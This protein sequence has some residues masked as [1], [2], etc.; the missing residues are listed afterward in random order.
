MVNV[1]G[2]LL[3]ECSVEDPE[4]RQAEVEA[5]MALVCA[6]IRTTAGCSQAPATFSMDGG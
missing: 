1:S 2:G 5:C 3:S 4:Q 6:S